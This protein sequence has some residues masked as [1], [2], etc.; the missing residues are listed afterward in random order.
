MQLFMTKKLAEGLSKWKHV[1]TAAVSLLIKV[2]S[3]TLST[4]L[5]IYAFAVVL[6]LQLLTINMKFI[7]LASYDCK[8]TI[9]C[10]YD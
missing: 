4:F 6:Y 1:T 2:F 8:K 10:L 9:L 7:I 3:P 5:C